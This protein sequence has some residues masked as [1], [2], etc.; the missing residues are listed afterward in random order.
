MA[1]RKRLAVLIS[2]QLVRLQTP[3]LDSL[4]ALLP[5]DTG[6]H[7]VVARTVYTRAGSSAAIDTLPA[8]CS[9]DD[10]PLEAALVAML[11]AKGFAR[12]TADVLRASVLDER[13]ARVDAAVAAANPKLWDAT[14]TL[15]RRVIHGNVQRWVHNGRMLYLRHLAYT[16]AL[17]A[18][19]SAPYDLILC[20]REDNAFVHPDRPLPTEVDL[21][22]RRAHSSRT[23]PRHHGRVLL[24]SHCGFLGAPSDKVSVSDAS[25]ARALLGA[26]GTEHIDLLLRWLRFG[27]ERANARNADP[28]QS[29]A[30][31]VHQLKARHVAVRHVAFARTDVRMERP[32]VACVRPLYYACGP[33]ELRSRRLFPMCAPTSKHER[34]LH[35]KYGE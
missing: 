17:E 20:L 13:M 19:G 23:H 4:A 7:L 2:G 12:A 16:A 31:L 14:A 24:D 28:L 11:R 10:G 35:E 22:T 27:L 9:L 18:A 29:E 32:G 25:G 3:Q 15:R 21:L 5:F 8:L 26:N 30:F 33:E 1:K 34:E 6:V